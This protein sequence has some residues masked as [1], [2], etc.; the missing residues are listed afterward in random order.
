MITTDCSKVI[1]DKPWLVFTCFYHKFIQMAIHD[2]K[3][4]IVFTGIFFDSSLGC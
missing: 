3:I 4:K 2:Q 1:N